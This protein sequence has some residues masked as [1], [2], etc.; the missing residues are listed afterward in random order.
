M[1][2]VAVFG[3]SSSHSGALVATGAKLM[4]TGK[5]V[6]VA[7]D[8]HTPHLLPPPVHPTITFG[9]VVS[10]PI[11][12]LMV[13]GKYVAAMSDVLTCSGTLVATGVKLMV[14]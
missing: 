13:S 7:A 1:R 10:S 2:P 8:K 6:G 3:D 5:I 4:V 11:S 12:K 9:L 14:T